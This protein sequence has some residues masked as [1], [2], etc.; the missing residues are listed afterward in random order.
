MLK[1]AGGV[2]TIC[3][4]MLCVNQDLDLFLC[5]SHSRLDRLTYN[6]SHF[7][8]TQHRHKETDPQPVS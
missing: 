1:A 5:F 4:N 6:Q 7:R 8:Q 2:Y 3:L